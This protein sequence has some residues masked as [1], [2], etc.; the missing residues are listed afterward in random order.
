MGLHNSSSA[1]SQRALR[2]WPPWPSLPSKYKWPRPLLFCL[3]PRPVL[4]SGIW[5][6]LSQGASHLPLPASTFV[7]HKCTAL[8]CSQKAFTSHNFTEKGNGATEK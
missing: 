6:K 8:G 5:R 2:G 3:D 4:E 1:A 7:A